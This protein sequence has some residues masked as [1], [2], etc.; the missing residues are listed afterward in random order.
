[1]YKSITVGFAFFTIATVLGALWAADAWGGYWSWDPKETWALIVWLNYAAWLHMRLVKGLRGTVAAWWALAGPGG[2]DLRLPGG[3]HVPER[4]A[5]L[6][7]AVDAGL[8]AFRA[9]DEESETARRN[10]RV[11]KSGLRRRTK[12]R[13]Q[14]A[15]GAPCRFIPARPVATRQRLHPPA[16]Q[17]DHAA[18]PIYEGRRD[19]LKLMATG[20]AGAALA[21][22][23]VGARP[24]RRRRAKARTSWPLPACQ[25]GGVLVR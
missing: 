23:G 24:W 11:T 22:M 10:T 4:A 20:A 7:H 6:R 3:E 5:Q 17:R 1:M 2:H 14:N 12:L 25:V 13:H 16:V 8:H 15:K 21:G 19:M 9:F 18:Q